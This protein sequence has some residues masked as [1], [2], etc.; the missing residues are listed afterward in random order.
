MSIVGPRPHMVNV[1]KFYGKA[2]KNFNLRHYVKPGITGFAQVKGYRGLV[3]SNHDMEKRVRA[4]SYYVRN[5][6]FLLDL[7]IIFQTIILF[8]KGDENAV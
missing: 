6:S 5:W 4:D 2:I 3:D 7:K 8:I 1:N